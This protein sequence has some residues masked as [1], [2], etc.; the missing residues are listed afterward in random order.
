MKWLYV[1]VNH[2]INITK[3]HLLQMKLHI[4]HVYNLIVIVLKFS[5]INF[6]IIYIKKCKKLKF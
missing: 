2:V 4:H 1:R 3:S 6:D 5:K